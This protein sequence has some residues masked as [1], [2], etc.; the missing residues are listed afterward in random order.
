LREN[1]FIVN[2]CQLDVIRLAPPLIIS[3]D[4]VDALLA[5]LAAALS[6]QASALS[7]KASTVD[8]QS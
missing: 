4:Q 1:G 3:A 6:R 7:P 8:N 2:P 5:A